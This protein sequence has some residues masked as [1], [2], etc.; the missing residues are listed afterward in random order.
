MYDPRNNPIAGDQPVV[1]TGDAHPVPPSGA[2]GQPGA[3]AGGET[4]PHPVPVGGGEVIPIPGQGL[5]ESLH[6]NV[7][8]D[9]GIFYGEVGVDRDIDATASHTFSDGHHPLRNP[10]P[11]ITKDAD[12]TY[13]DDT[14]VSHQGVATAVQLGT[15]TGPTAADLQS[16]EP[17]ADTSDQLS[18]LSPDTAVDPPQDLESE[19]RT[20]TEAG[21]T[22][23]DSFYGAGEHNQSVSTSASGPISQMDAPGANIALGAYGMP[24][25]QQLEGEQAARMQPPTEGIYSAHITDGRPQRTG[26]IHVRGGDADGFAYDKQDDQNPEPT[27]NMAADLGEKYIVTSVSYHHGEVH[28]NLAAANV[29]AAVVEL[30]SIGIQDADIQVLNEGNVGVVKVKVDNLNRPYVEQT[31]HKYGK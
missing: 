21:S 14:E 5:A 7:E 20:G 22:L 27:A 19:G 8:D 29:A 17:G 15:T 26:N 1:S 24:G 23:Q 25:G 30:R 9:S 10:V 6:G 11:E 12:L 3:A 4:L 16:S 13:L 2:G 18:A 28:A 31:L